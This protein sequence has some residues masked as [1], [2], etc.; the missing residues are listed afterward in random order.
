MNNYQTRSLNDNNNTSSDDKVLLSIDIEL[1]EDNT[2]V[3]EIRGKDN[4]NYKINDFCKKNNLSE[5]IKTH[6]TNLVKQKIQKEIKD[7][8]NSIIYNNV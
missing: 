3:L 1:T 4:I 8:I 2:A 7:C 5:E 6:L